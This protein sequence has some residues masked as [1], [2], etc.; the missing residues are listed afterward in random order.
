M[1]D[2]NQRSSGRGH[3]LAF[4]V[5]IISAVIALFLILNRQYVVDQLAV[6]QYQPGAGIT[7]LADRS[8]MNDKGKFFFYAS[9]PTLEAAADF[10]TKCDRKEQSTAILGCYTGQNIYIY[11]VT[12]TKLDGIREV[13]AAHEMLHAAYERLSSE[14]KNKVNTLLDAEY[15]KLK[16]DKKL[17]ERMAFYARTEPG[18]RENELHSVIGTEVTSI[19]PELE[20]YYKKYFTDRGS[21]VGLHEKYESVFTD[22]Q[23][24]GQSLADQLTE[25]GDTIE[26]DSVD[27]NKDVN[28]LN[29]AIAA[30][31]T[32]AENGGFATQNDFEAARDALMGRASEL[33]AKRKE[34]NNKVAQYEALRQELV[35]IASQSEALNR[36]IDSSL[37]PTP[38]L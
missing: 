27:Y 31:N 4:F 37:A 11:N 19:S 1:S 6:W 22:L 9:H 20:E 16:N 38:S 30:F 21:L 35:S 7:A 12:D 29:S 28:S 23:E 18:E 5:A 34:I 3:K 15:E 13:T 8:T 36:S 10:N 32:K 2:T 14:E 24:R 25:L 17:A 33:E 26:A